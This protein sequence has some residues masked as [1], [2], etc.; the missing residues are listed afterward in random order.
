MK[1]ILAFG[2]SNSKQSINVQL[3]RYAAQLLSNVQINFI[4]LNDFEMPIFSIDRENETGIPKPAHRFKSLIKASDGILISFAEHNGSYSVAFK[5]ILDWTSRIEQ[6][7]WLDKPM[8][9]LATSPGRRGGQSVLQAA[10][11]RFPFMGGIVLSHFSLPSFNHTFDAQNGITDPEL[12][13]QLQE[14]LQTFQNHF[15]A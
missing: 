11:T 8:C 3:V 5:N 9:L 2:G 14:A 1:T 13:R 7:L 12:D 15:D 10:C 6:N 4:D